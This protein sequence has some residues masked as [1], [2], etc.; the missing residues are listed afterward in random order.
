VKNIDKYVPTKFRI[1]SRGR[2]RA[3]RD[4]RFLWTA[5]RLVAE[6]V[7]QFYGAAF[8]KY[9]RGRLIDLG[10]GRAPFYVG[11]APFVSAVTCVDW[12][13]PEGSASHLDATQDLRA[14]LAFPNAAFDT[15]LLSDVLEHIPTPEYLME[16]IS[17]VLAPGGVLLM[18]VPFMYLL[19][20]QPHDY[21][22]YTEFALRRFVDIA[23]LELL[24]LAPLGGSFDVFADFVGKHLNMIPL[25]G[26]PPARFIQFAAF[27]FGKTKFGERIRAKS[28]RH[29]PLGY[30]LVARRP[31]AAT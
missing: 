4:D 3:T 20:E 26:G 7:A 17:R 6:L 27:A 23:G 8:Q 13:E 11:Y 28:G 9:A 2:L 16:E 5:S 31:L 25:V 30:A 24:E 29:F 22:R 1:D 21:Y 10:C 12:N 15:V 14:S 18:N 19:H